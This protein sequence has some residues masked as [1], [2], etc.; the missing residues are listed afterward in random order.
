MTPTAIQR[1]ERG[2]RITWSDGQTHAY[3]ATKLRAA[4][5]CATC[6]EKKEA[7][8]QPKNMLPVLSAADVRP[9][10][11]ESMR[12]VG[13]YAYAISYS[14]GHGSGLYQFDLLRILGEPI[15]AD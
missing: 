3:T 4:C 5:P 7:P 14:D 8:Q 15:A 1:T 11:I 12:P 2:L 10:E 13:S 6:R 9:L